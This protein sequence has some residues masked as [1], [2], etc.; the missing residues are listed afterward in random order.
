MGID[1]VIDWTCEPK[2]A[3]GVANIVQLV[4]S[5]D[6]GVA[7]LQAARAA[8]DERLLAELSLETIV[9][10]RIE[11]VERTTVQALL[12]RAAPL[13]AHADRCTPCPANRGARGGYGCYRSIPYPI[14]AVAEEWLLMRLPDS[15]D[16]TAGWMRRARSTTSSGMARPLPSCGRAVGLFSRARVPRVST[17]TMCR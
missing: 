15:L 16:S 7:V 4:K 8:G 3:I 10:T 17:G 1:Y 11:R 12:A 2:R 14:P 6:R 9:R 5:R 13:E